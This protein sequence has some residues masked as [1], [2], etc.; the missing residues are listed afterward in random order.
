MSPDQN[1]DKFEN[2]C[3]IY[4]YAKSTVQNAKKFQTQFISINSN[5]K[6]M[7]HYKGSNNRI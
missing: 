7:E 3:H 5:G 4:L 6:I 1:A 2:S